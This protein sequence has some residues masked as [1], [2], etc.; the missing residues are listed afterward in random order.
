MPTIIE[1]KVVPSSGKNKWILDAGGRLKCY[2]KSPPEKGLANRELIKLVAKALSISNSD[3]EIV[4]GATSR[5]KRLKVGIDIS[6]DQF[7][8]KVGLERQKS[9]F[10]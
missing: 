8:E 10:E 1:L 2:L 5:N 9:L 4:S 7:L 3:V 6:F